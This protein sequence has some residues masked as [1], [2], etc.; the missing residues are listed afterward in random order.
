MIEDD[1]VAH[2]EY[3][4]EVDDD[5]E[6][7]RALRMQKSIGAGVRRRCWEVVGKMRG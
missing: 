7:L 2:G 3:S 1:Q 6:K 5:Q 4:D